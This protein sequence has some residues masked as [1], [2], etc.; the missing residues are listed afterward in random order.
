MTLSIAET[1]HRSSGPTQ[2]LLRETLAGFRHNENE[3]NAV[4]C[5]FPPVKAQVEAQVQTLCPSKGVSQSL[6]SIR[7]QAKPSPSSLMSACAPRPPSPL[8]SQNLSHQVFLFFAFIGQ[9]QEEIDYNQEGASSLFHVS[10]T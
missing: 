4:A 9:I 1:L 2:F 6:V 8:P 5:Y 10:K 3:A 7:A